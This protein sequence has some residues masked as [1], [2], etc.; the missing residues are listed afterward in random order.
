[1]NGIT[2]TFLSLP[3][4]GALAFGTVIG[5]YV[6]YINRYRKDASVGDITT[7]ISALGGATITAIFND[8][9]LFGAYSLG[10][11]IGF[12]GYFAILLL[13]VKLS[14]NF[15]RDFFLDGRHKK[16]ADD[17]EREPE[18]RPMIVNLLKAWKEE[19]NGPPPV[20][21]LTGRKLDDIS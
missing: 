2:S 9:M 12:F 18:Q 19:E 7:L 3:S 20:P 14:T 15:N 8:K 10:L 11:G 21:A 5:W 17:E 13:L 1:M 6:Y 4:L 16:L